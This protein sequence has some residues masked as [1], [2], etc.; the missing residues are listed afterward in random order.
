MLTHWLQEQT[1]KLR[2]RNIAQG[3]AETDALWREWYRRQIGKGFSLDEPPPPP[4]NHG[5][6]A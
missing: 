1:Q 2:A 3:R 5:D 6:G 4:E